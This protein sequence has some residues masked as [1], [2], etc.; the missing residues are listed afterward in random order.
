MYSNIRGKDG[1]N[2]NNEKLHSLPMHLKVSIISFRKLGQALKTDLSGLTRSRL[3]LHSK[4]N[5][6]DI[7]LKISGFTSVRPSSALKGTDSGH[8]LV[9]PKLWVLA[10]AWCPEHAT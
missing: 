9:K 3:H 8:S 10:H 1:E 7:G 2:V 6:E 5:W 4:Q